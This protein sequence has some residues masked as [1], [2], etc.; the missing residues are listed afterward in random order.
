MN[1]NP[2]S[3]L[4]SA[5][6]DELTEYPQYQVRSVI[7]P[8]D[9]T[10]EST[11]V[12]PVAQKIAKQ[13]SAHL[14]I[15]HAG[16][17][18]ADPRRKLEDL[19]VDPVALRGAILEQ[20]SGNPAEALL[21]SVRS[22]S[23]P[24]LVMCTHTKP[25]GV[26][27]GVGSVTRAVICGCSIPVLLIP[28]ER[29]YSDWE[30]KRVLFPHDGTPE[31]AVGIGR[32]FYTAYEISAEV[33]VFHV[34]THAECGSCPAPGTLS[35]PRYVDQWQHEIPSW[36]REF[37]ERLEALSHPPSAVKLNL[38]MAAGDPAEE[39]LRFAREQRVDVIVLIWHGCWNP[40]RAQIVRKVLDASLCPVLLLRVPPPST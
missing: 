1:A 10:V 30:A 38:F 21:P 8:L 26:E 18:I 13:K 40:E 34:S 27:G 11:R 36:T 12:L 23:G 14:Y 29:T 5:R 28:P 24:V 2:V 37:L 6:T 9:G 33:L 35:S 25:Q 15:L 31:S 4:K 3:T 32:A 19:G 16:R 39:I 7:V 17:E 22:K 20:N